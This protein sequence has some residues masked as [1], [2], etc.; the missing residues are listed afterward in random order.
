MTKFTSAFAAGLLAAV[1]MTPAAALAATPKDT[2]VI[3]TS[4]DDIVSIDP[5]EAFG[6]SGGDLLQN[7]HDRLVELEPKDPSAGYAPGPAASRTVSK[8]AETRGGKEW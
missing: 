5:A 6:F 1:A 2:L 3:A 8:H 4:I 7:T